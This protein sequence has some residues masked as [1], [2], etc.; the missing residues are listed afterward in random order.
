M[1]KE[2]MPHVDFSKFESSP[3]IA[4][5]GELITVQ[6]LVEFVDRKLAA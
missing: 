3:E 6:S 1:L 4:K 5:V 2:R